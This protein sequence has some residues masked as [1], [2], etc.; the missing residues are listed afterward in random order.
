MVLPQLP[1]AGSA[2]ARPIRHATLLSNHRRDRVDVTAPQEGCLCCR[3]LY[4]A[5][6]SPAGTL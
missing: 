2:E 5:A 6:A 3:L 4:S 1:P